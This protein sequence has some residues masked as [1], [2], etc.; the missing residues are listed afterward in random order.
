MNK[1]KTISINPRLAPSTPPKPQ[2]R[3]R[4]KLFEPMEELDLLRMPGVPEFP[5]KEYIDARTAEI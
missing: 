2:L 5:R 4:Y 3:L 1:K